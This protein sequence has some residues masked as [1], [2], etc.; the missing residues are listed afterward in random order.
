[1]VTSKIITSFI[2]QQFAK[3]WRKLISRYYKPAGITPIKTNWYYSNNKGKFAKNLTSTME[4]NA[5]TSF[6][7]FFYII[8]L[9]NN[10]EMDHGSC[11]FYTQIPENPANQFHYIFNFSSI[12]EKNISFYSTL[13]LPTFSRLRC[14]CAVL[15]PF[16]SRWWFSYWGKSICKAEINLQTGFQYSRNFYHFEKFISFQFVY[17]LAVFEGNVNEKLSDNLVSEW[18]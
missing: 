9:W 7:L 8:L 16:S 1:M 18:H 2:F 10:L 17:L 12:S 13:F 4:K 3:N 14:C 15:W 11:D 5:E 6:L